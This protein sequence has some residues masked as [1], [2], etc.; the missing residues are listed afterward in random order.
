MAPIPIPAGGLRLRSLVAGLCLSA[1]APVT[2]AESFTRH[3]EYQGIRFAIDC[4][5]DASINRLRVQ[6][7]GLAIDNAAVETEIDG[8]VVDAGVADLDA[9]GSPEVYV[10]VS[11]AGSGSYGSLAA[12]A[13]NKGRSLSGIYLPPLSPEEAYAQGYM[14][15]DR[16]RLTG[17][18]LVRA[19]P[20]YLEGDPNSQ[21]TGGMR[22]LEYRLVPGEAGWLLELAGIR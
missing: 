16:F 20:V 1:L 9:D 19:F 6:P 22:E 12:W 18:R 7:A 8:T 4:D 2:S 17:D 13:V 15:H 3:L 14:G 5:N 21:P 10:F 11:S